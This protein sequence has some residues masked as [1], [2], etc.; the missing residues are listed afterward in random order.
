VLAGALPLVWSVAQIGL[1]AL[2]PAPQS[3]APRASLAQALSGF[4]SAL[5]QS[6][7]FGWLYFVLVLVS[8]PRALERSRAARLVAAW[9][10]LYLVLYLAS[11]MATG[12]SNWFFFLRLVP[13]WFGSL[14][15]LAAAYSTLAGRALVA[16][17]V[18][19]GLLALGG[20][21][22]LRALLAAARPGALAE[23]WTLLV[24]TQGYDFREYLERFLPHVRGSDEQRV[25][26]AKHFDADARLLAPELAGALYGASG[27]ELPQLIES[28]KSA[29]GPGWELGLSGLGL[30]V[31][32]SFGHQLEQGF[33]R[34]AQQ[35]PE[36]RAAL[37]E[38]LGRIALG[39]KYDEDKLRAAANFPAPP[40]LRAAFLRGGGW[41]LYELHRLRPDRA[42]AFLATL[43]PDQRAEVERGWREAAELHSLR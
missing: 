22:D 19:L 42:R 24:R 13:L 17:R 20:L 33:A 4:T 28:W 7:L 1:G 3:A 16:A 37:A 25:A 26:I 14:L 30:A 34:I 9:L 6:D 23:N 10:A 5:A 15:L 21:L 18:A 40:E 31:D 39:L 38:A 11:G 29:W 36:L 41:R 43:P 32:P 2:R 27:R 8:L 12:N 35:P